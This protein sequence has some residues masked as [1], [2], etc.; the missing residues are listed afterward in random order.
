MPTLLEV[1][2]AAGFMEGEGS[3]YA[4]K[5]VNGRRAVGH[6]VCATQK[7]AEPL[8]RLQRLFGGKLHT[9]VKPEGT[10]TY[11]QLCGPQ[12][13]G[14]A[15]T[16]YTLM[17]PKRQEQISAMIISWRERDSGYNANRAKTHCL[18]GHEFT[19]EN[20]YIGKHGNRNCR[21]CRRVQYA[22]A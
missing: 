9:R 10:Y 3:F 19:E 6:Y 7:Q 20:T 22:A 15:M 4:V 17:S 16:L 2:W 13:M 14:V 12:A 8:E 18:R 5:V 21:A 1:A 11:W